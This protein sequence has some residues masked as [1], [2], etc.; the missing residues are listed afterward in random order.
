MQKSWPDRVKLMQY[1]KSVTSIHPETVN[2]CMQL[3][4]SSILFPCVIYYPWYKDVAI[5]IWIQTN[6]L[7]SKCMP[8]RNL[9]IKEYFNFNIH[10]SWY[11]SKSSLATFIL[12]MQILG[13]DNLYWPLRYFG[14]KLC[15]KIY[16]N[17]TRVAINSVLCNT[18]IW[19]CAYG[20]SQ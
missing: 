15:W 12:I 20:H 5:L 14:L 8:V 16:E 9:K 19:K 3:T 18:D 4:K 13:S 6:W 17:M 2:K 7:Y 10:I 1:L 11:M